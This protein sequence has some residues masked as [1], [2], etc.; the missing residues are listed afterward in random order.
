MSKQNKKQITPIQFFVTRYFYLVTIVFTGVVYLYC[1]SLIWLSIFDENFSSL[2]GNSL[3]QISLLINIYLIAWIWFILY[4]FYA[5]VIKPLKGPLQILDEMT[6]DGLL[7][8]LKKKKKNDLFMMGV[9]LREVRHGLKTGK[10]IFGAFG[11]NIESQFSKKIKTLSEQNEQLKASEKKLKNA[12][13]SLALE[14]AKSDAIINSVGSAVIASSKAGNI[15][16]MNEQAET[17]LGWDKEKMFGKII[18]NSFGLCED[19]G[20]N[21]P[22]SSMPSHQARLGKKKSLTFDYTRG[23]E[24]VKIEDI[25]TPITLNGEIIGVVDIMRDVTRENE[26][27]RAQRDFV[28]IA[29]HQLRTPTST[30]AWHAQLLMSEDLSTHQTDLVAEIYHQNSRMRD[31]INALLHVSRIDL[32]KLRFLPQSMNIEHILD[33]VLG[34]QKLLI[35]KKH[36]RV[37]PLVHISDKIV[38][39][40]VVIQVILDN[41]VSNAVKYS[42]PEGVISIRIKSISEQNFMI[43]IKDTGIGIPKSER[44]EIF[45]RLFRATNARDYE[46]DG[47]G[48]G[49]YTVKTMVLAM[50]GKIWFESEQGKGSSFFVEL[51]KTLPITSQSP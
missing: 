38:S 27:E 48:L 25:A 12:L 23:G 24:V 37:E 34:D 10:G 7:K 44:S 11:Q 9:L 45:S 29:S 28:S 43:E 26:V 47:H 46:P 30:I 32:G 4:G 14:K 15:F 51:P 36:I 21:I 22:C 35:Q 3:A 8:D 18:E 33:L 42:Y 39:D 50:K 49:L 20:G 16:L 41:L 5:M 1:F 40:P 19:R 6:Q 13:H 31:L 2:I 17:L